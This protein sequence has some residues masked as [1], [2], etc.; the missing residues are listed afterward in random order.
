LQGIILKDDKRYHYTEN[1]LKNR[2]HT[3]CEIDKPPAEL[4][5]VVFPFMGDIPQSTYDNNYF[6]ALKDKVQVFSGIRSPYLECKCKEHNLSYNV[7]MED[8]AVQMKNAIPTSE[9]VIAYL[10]A[11]RIDTLA[12]SR[13]L[14]IGYGACGSDLAKRLRGLGADVYALV[15]NREKYSTAYADRISPIYIDELFEKVTFEIIINT[16]PEQVLGNDM[17]KNTG[18]AL[19][20]DIASKPHGFDIEYAK[21]FNEKS[22]ILPG[23]PGKYA[24]RCSGEIIGEYIDFILKALQNNTIANDI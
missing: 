5:F 7:I 3:F 9:G 10:I 15:R 2:G 8:R 11:N 21:K 19:L 23:I 22:T 13:I 17:I 12:N 4:D 20:V 1:Y 24:T 16:V 14:I 18:G 6:A